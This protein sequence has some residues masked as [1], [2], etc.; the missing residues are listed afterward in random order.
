VL[1]ERRRRKGIAEPAHRLLYLLW[2]TKR[3]SFTAVLYSFKE[4]SNRL[5]NS[6]VFIDKLIIEVGKT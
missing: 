3:P 6:R 5:R 1:Q 4:I 2:P